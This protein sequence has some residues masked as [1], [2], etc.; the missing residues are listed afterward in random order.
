MTWVRRREHLD[1]RV[2]LLPTYL[3]TGRIDEGG[4]SSLSLTYMPYHTL[5][6]SR[7]QFQCDA[8]QNALLAL[9]TDK[10]ASPVCHNTSKPCRTKD[11]VQQ[12]NGT[13]SR[14]HLKPEPLATHR[15]DKGGLS[16]VALT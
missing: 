16:S 8:Y 15:I 4:I 6:R 9:G 7:Q 1:P 12:L 5:D 10:G 3:A 14:M 2:C 11:T 13:S